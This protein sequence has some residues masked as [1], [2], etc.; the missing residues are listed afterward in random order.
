MEKEKLNRIKTLLNE[1]RDS[2]MEAQLYSRD[3]LNLFVGMV[4]GAQSPR[5]SKA[6]AIGSAA[7]TVGTVLKGFWKIYKKSHQPQTFTIKITEDDQIFEIVEDWLMEALPEEDQRSVYAHSSVQKRD[8]EQGRSRRSRLGLAELLDDDGEKDRVTI[9]YSFDGTIVQKLT[10]RGHEVE[11]YTVVPEA[12]G[13]KKD[14]SKSSVWNA[15][16]INLVCQS[17][18]ARNAVLDEIEEKSQHLV[19]SQP[20]MFIAG[21]YGDWRR[22]NE[23]QRR[24]RDSVVLKEGQMDRIIGYLTDFLSHKEAY[25]KAD[26][27]FRTGILLHGEPGSGKSSTALAIANELKMNVFIIPLSAL[28][29]DESLSDCFANIPPNSIV[30]LEDIDIVKAVKDRDD[31]D[32]QGVTMQG[33]LNVLDGFQS[34]PG[35]ITIMTTNR[36]EVLNDAIIRPGRVDMIENLDCLDDYQLRGLCSYFMGKIPANL[37][38]ITP[39]DKITSAEVMGVVRKHLPDFE[40]ADE[41]MVNFVSDRL[42]TKIEEASKMETL[43]D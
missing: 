1:D 42:L 39:A 10:I 22:R 36:L 35:V 34:P 40:N 43:Q 21:R 16:S 17:V 18:E 6:V 14:S 13:T 3:L 7:Y 11:I 26:I 37:P 31:N 2:K 28:L 29:N 32:E 30:I 9:D 33:M 38:H 20:R 24:G 4:E 12:Y 5:L 23:I 27:P 41:D 25:M 19:K 8:E 15:R